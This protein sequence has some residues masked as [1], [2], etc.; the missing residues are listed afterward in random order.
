MKTTANGRVSCARVL[1]AMLCNRTKGAD[2]CNSLAFCRTMGD[3]CVPK[4][5][6]Q[7][8]FGATV[9]EYLVSRPTWP[10]LATGPNTS[11]PCFG[12]STCVTQL[13]NK[14]Q[15]PLLQG[16]GPRLLSVS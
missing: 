6:N 10:C 12:C 4:L 8:N 15:R 13:Q 9:Q 16:L 2:D 5:Y 3:T 11:T 7:D 14:T 1:Q